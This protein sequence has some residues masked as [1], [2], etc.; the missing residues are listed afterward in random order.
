MTEIAHRHG[1]G[2]WTGASDR[3]RLREDDV[4]VYAADL[5]HLDVTDASSVDRLVTDVLDTHGR[6]DILVNI[7]GI[8]GPPAPSRPTRLRTGAACWKST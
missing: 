7:A 2:P 8:A 1:R 5:P 6:L 4:H 3:R